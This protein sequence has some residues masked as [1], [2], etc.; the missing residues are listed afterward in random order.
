MKRDCRLYPITIFVAFLVFFT[1][2]NPVTGQES[3]TDYDGNVYRIAT[4]GTQVWMTENLKTTHYADGLPIPEIQDDSLW[5]NLTD[6]AYCAN[7]N[8]KSNVL[9]FGY[10]YNWYTVPNGKKV[11]PVGWHV[12]SANEWKKLETFLGGP[13][14][15]GGRMKEEGTARWDEPNIKADN[16]SGF[17]A[18]PG[19]S[20]NPDGTF[21]VTGEN[22]EWWTS[23]EF[24]VTT[25]WHRRLYNN[26]GF[27]DNIYALKT[28]GFSVRCLRDN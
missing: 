17:N 15:A 19:G 9:L 25:A 23:T 13:G 20:R 28:E 7:N 26:V 14:T 3:V 16:S 22:G 12:P 11:C 21:N 2:F 1:V 6:G 27:I 10:L 24:S 5:A 18:L 8:E 4:I